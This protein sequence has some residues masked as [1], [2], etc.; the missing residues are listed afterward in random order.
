MGSLCALILCSL[1]SQV[2]LRPGRKIPPPHQQCE[3]RH[4]CWSLWTIPTHFPTLWNDLGLGPVDGVGKIG[5]GAPRLDRDKGGRWQTIA[6]GIHCTALE[7]TRRLVPSVAQSHNE[8]AGPTDCCIQRHWCGICA[9]DWCWQPPGAVGC[10]LI[11]TVPWA[12]ELNK[13]KEEE[14][15]TS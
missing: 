12:A 1:W 4:S 6:C 7:H 2:L 9:D 5:A 13:Q 15:R 3:K 11:C 14:K 10:A 8:L